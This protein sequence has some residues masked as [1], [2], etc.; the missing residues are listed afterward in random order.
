MAKCKALTG[1][2]VKGLKSIPHHPT[3]QDETLAKVSQ[4]LVSSYSVVSLG[5]GCSVS[6]DRH[7]V[8]YRPVASS[9]VH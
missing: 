7:R 1:S 5:D 8:S 2:A 6:V 3:R 4:R 9:S